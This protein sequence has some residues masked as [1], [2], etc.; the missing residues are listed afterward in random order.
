MSIINP[1]IDLIK[2]WRKPLYQ[3]KKSIQSISCQ[4]F[5]PYIETLEKILT[6][7]IIPFWYPE[8]MDFEKG[9]YRLNHDIQGKWKGRSN[10]S[11][12]AQAR[13]VWFFSRLVNSEYGTQDHLKAAR[14]G[15]EFLKVR[16]WDKEYG[17][18]FWEVDSSGKIPTKPAKH[19]YG[20]A[21]ALYALSEFALAS[22]DSSSKQLAH[23]LFYLLEKKAHDAQY[24]GYLEFFQPNWTSVA[25]GVKSYLNSSSSMKLMNTHLHLMEAI[26]TYHQLTQDTISR[27]RLIELILVLSSA[28]RCE[29]ICACMDKYYRDWA[30]IDK[31]TKDCISYGHI[32]E[33]IWLLI[34]GCT[35]AG[36]SKGPFLNLY[37]NLFNYTIRFG[38]DKNKGGFYYTGPY[39][40]T[41]RRI[42]KVWWVQ[43]EALMSS[44]HMYVQTGEGVYF[45]CFSRILE[46]ITLYQID[47]EY[48]DW[49]AKVNKRGKPSGD[50]A[51]PWKTPYH[52]GR[53]MIECIQLLRY[54]AES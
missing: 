39:N 52:N 31:H 23:E 40:A 33:N 13:T 44:L 35:T 2:L 25:D 26:A 12:V 18:F 14:H 19:L 27:E 42:E 4:D 24:G 9:G 21:F 29:T 48:G 22:G 45:Q 37:R 50:K 53:A 11:L 1:L 46:W 8:F 43:A 30:P 38:E 47:W 32:L 15:Y 34:T 3:G 20:Q 16:M 7:N 28:V 49:H 54:I 17:G 6:E 36:I 41:A 51:G 10:K 5:L